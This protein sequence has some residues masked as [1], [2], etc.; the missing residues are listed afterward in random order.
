MT[1]VVFDMMMNE[2]DYENYKV[3]NTGTEMTDEICQLQMVTKHHLATEVATFTSI[4]GSTLT[5][6]TDSWFDGSKT[7]DLYY[8]KANERLFYIGGVTGNP[9][10][11]QV[12]VSFTY[13]PDEYTSSLTS[14]DKIWLIEKVTGQNVD[15]ITTNEGQHIPI[16]NSGL[17]DIRNATAAFTHDSNI[18]SNGEIMK[19]NGQ[20]ING[21]MRRPMI[22]ETA[23]TALQ[24]NAF[25]FHRLTYD[26]QVGVNFYDYHDLDVI[27]MKAK[28]L[29]GEPNSHI[30]DFRLSEIVGA[31]DRDSASP[32]DEV[33]TVTPTAQVKLILRF[34]Y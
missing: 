28:R 1:E 3:N 2:V 13:E 9:T 21:Y 25:N 20:K 31:T 23:S 12:T 24:T 29:P 7:Q 8:Q 19:L 6:S 32:I 14:G 18:G 5:L 22:K 4:A 34:N 16:V 17:R 15:V 10:T 27:I 33:I 30:Q 26:G 11:N